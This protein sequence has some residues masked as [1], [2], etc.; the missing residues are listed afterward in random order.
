M[1][2]EA[3]ILGIMSY[4]TDIVDASVDRQPFAEKKRAIRAVEQLIIVG[5]S[6]VGIAVPQVCLF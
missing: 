1:F 6:H 2:L 4:F 3:H 5:K